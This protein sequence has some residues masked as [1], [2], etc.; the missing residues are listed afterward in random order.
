MA[1]RLRS[2]G[3]PLRPLDSIF[4]PSEFVVRIPSFHERRRQVLDPREPRLQSG[5]LATQ[6]V[7]FLTQAI[8]LG[9]GI[10]AV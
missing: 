3:P 8:D 9:G 10:H 6:S 4:E 2:S 1:V 5:A 7:I